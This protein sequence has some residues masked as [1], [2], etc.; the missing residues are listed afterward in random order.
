MLSAALNIEGEHSEIELS[1]LYDWL[2]REDNLRD[3][4]IELVPVAVAPETMGALSDTI[5]VVLG[6]GSAGAML[7]R[8]LSVWLTTRTADIKIKV[9]T[10][11]GTVQLDAH[12]VRDPAA[13]IEA[14]NVILED[15]DEA[16]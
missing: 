6:S 13:L 12:H 4:R 3:A 11:K 14:I 8:S 5:M 2:V 10:G 9:S 16:A 15:D 7:A 1:S